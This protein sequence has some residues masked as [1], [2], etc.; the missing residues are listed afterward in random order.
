[1]INTGLHLATTPTE[2]SSAAT[3]AASG[4]S[5]R[6]SNNISFRGNSSAGTAV[7]LNISPSTPTESKPL[8]LIEDKLSIIQNIARL[9]LDQF[10]RFCREGNDQLWEFFGYNTPQSKVATTQS[11]VATT[12]YKAATPQDKAATIIQKYFRGHLARK[13]HLP[14]HLYPRYHALCEKIKQFG[15]QLIPRAPDGQ[16]TVY[17]PQEMPEIVLKASGRKIAIKR[18]HQMQ[19][20]RSI[21]DSQNS[22]CLIIPKANLCQDFLVEQRLPINGDSYHNMGLYLSQPELFNK[23][24]RELTRLFSRVY[25]SDLVGWQKN[26]L[27]HIAG[28][29]DLVRYDN[30]P[31]YVVE[32]NEKKEGRIGLID[33]EHTSIRENQEGLSG[34]GLNTL[35]R[36]FPLHLDIIKDEA[37]K[38]KIKVDKVL[39]AYAEKGKKYLQVGFTDHLE[40]LRQKGILTETSLEPLQIS[41]QRMEEVIALVEKELLKLNQ[42]V[43][44]KFAGRYQQPDKNFF[45]K[46]PE[47]TAKE[48][49]A[50]LTPFVINYIK[51]ALEYYIKGSLNLA[52]NEQLSEI[53]TKNMT[54]SQL[55]SLRSPAIRREYLYV[56]TTELISENPKIK[57]EGDEAD[58]FSEKYRMSRLITSL[59]IEELVKGGE[60]F[61]FDPASYSAG[62]DLCWIR[63]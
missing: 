29:E 40:Y 20:V 18:F 27:G 62:D 31:L 35:A 2:N 63:Y 9:K 36:I 42:G 25:F 19:E 10:Q 21:L 14:S 49:A 32:E 47:E 53:Q 16:T 12:Q 11:K 45:I 23:A 22:S 56:D 8:K 55:V 59:I 50:S 4:G 7:H 24:V 26:P 13:P 43:E 1:M 58:D 57:F 48:L 41:P 33:L 54:E 17:L 39:D 51:D 37:S 5:L 15:S 44:S 61:H 28:V 34:S 38:L 46:D 6:T 3:A 60:I 52:Q 30:L